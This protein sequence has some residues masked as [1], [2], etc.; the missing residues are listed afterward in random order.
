M[1]NIVR[2]KVAEILAWMHQ[3]SVARL[4]LEVPWEVYKG[5]IRSSP[6]DVLVDV[7]RFGDVPSVVVD[8]VVELTEGTEGVEE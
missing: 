8:L 4:S 5:I 2:E 7:V 6:G 1:S 3:H